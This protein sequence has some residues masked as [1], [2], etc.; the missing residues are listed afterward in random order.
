[1]IIEIGVYVGS[2]DAFMKYAVKQMI[3]GDIPN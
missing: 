2:N 1:M 3:S